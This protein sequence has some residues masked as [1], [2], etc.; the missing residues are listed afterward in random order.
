MLYP[1]I[2]FADGMEVVYSEIKE[3]NGQ[4]YVTVKFER[5]NDER[6]DFDSMECDLPNGK[7]KN[8]IGFSKSE[9]DYHNECMIKLQDMIFECSK[10]NMEGKICRR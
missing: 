10:E 2:T 6:D 9:A 3:R 5:W 4:E 8:I 7:M 1:F